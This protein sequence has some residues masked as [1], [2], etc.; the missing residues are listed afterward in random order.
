V[1][2]L[3]SALIVVGAC[4]SSS[5]A[6][7]PAGL[8]DT[9]GVDPR[10]GSDPGGAIVVAEVE[11]ELG[12]LKETHYQHAIHVDEGA[13]AFDVDCSGFTDY[14]VARAMPAHFRELAAATAA[15]PLAE[16]W[17][18]F[19]GDGKAGSAAASR[20]QRVT[21]VDELVPGDF[22]AWL[23]PPDTGNTGHVVVVRQAPIKQTNESYEIA[24]WD[25][26]HS[27]HGATD[28]RS[29]SHATGIGLATIVLYADAAT[30][31]PTGH[32]WYPGATR[33]NERV[34]MGRAR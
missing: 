5:G 12:L 10:E 27:P 6:R 19:F 1:R 20:W 14:L 30:G 32:A 16:D 2:S 29:A 22:V 24:I 11:R 23:A 17:V 3:V 34:A 4:S 26:T 25:S 13:G 9:S 33:S 31:A 8:P 28:A 18:A 21:R 15:R 7:D